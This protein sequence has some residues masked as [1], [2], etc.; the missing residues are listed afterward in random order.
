MNKRPALPI[1]LNSRPLA[2]G[3]GEHLLIEIAG[4]IIGA[5]VAVFDASDQ[6]P[7]VMIEMGLALT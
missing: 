1:S 3:S 6:N 5:D 2:A 4:D 7:N